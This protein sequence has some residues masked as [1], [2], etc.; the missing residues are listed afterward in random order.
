VEEVKLIWDIIEDNV[1]VDCK[2]IIRELKL[3]FLRDV[4]DLGLKEA[5]K[6]WAKKNEDEI[7]VLLEE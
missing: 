4:R 3:E 1:P 5:L 7:D 6:K 2:D